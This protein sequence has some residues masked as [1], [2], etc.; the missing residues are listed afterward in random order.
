VPDAVKANKYKLGFELI[1][2]GKQEG[3]I[4]K[5]DN[6]VI[7]AIMGAIMSETVNLITSKAINFNEEDLDMMFSA[8]WDAI[9]K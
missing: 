5:L 7:A 9:K 2:L 6:E 8:F 1:D 3:L 4:K